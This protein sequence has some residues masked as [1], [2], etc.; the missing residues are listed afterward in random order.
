[1]LNK[2]AEPSKCYEANYFPGD[3]ESLDVDSFRD[4]G[5]SMIKS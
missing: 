2:V 1:M 3:K 5:S 4:S